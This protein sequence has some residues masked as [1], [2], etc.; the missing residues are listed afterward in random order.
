[1]RAASRAVVTVGFGER[2][3][4]ALRISLEE[5]SH[6]ESRRRRPDMSRLARAT[7]R[8]DGATTLVRHRGHGRW[9]L[10]DAGKIEDFFVRRFGRPLPVSAF[11]ETALHDGLG[12]D[13]QAAL[14]V[15]LLPDSVD[16]TALMDYLRSEGIS[17]LAY[18][19]SVPGAATDAHIH[20]GEPSPKF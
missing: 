15:A 17:F 20:V 6:G 5:R 12:L 16:G 14:D 11:G 8:R 7:D 19:S 3:S 9:S 18:R 4:V 13:H 10:A 1:M 2:L